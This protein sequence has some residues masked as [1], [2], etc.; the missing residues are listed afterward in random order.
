MRT[1]AQIL[2]ARARNHGFGHWDMWMLDPQHYVLTNT[3]MNYELDL[4]EISCASD[5]FHWMAHMSGKSD[6][7]GKDQVFELGCAFNDIYAYAGSEQI[8]WD[9][10]KV[11][12]AYCRTEGARKRC[13][14]KS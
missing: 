4:E 1:G 10:K 6:V 2:D 14:W 13:D 7:Y 3:L 8:G 12:N 11:V 5:L 9:S